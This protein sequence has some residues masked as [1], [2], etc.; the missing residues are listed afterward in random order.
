MLVFL[1][2]VIL[3][4]FFIEAFLQRRE[5]RRAR[6]ESATYY[7]WK[8]VTRDGVP[9]AQWRGQLE[10]ELAPGIVYRNRPNQAT[11]SFSINSRGFRGP[12]LPNSKFRP[13]ILLG[14]STA[15]GTGS[16]S[17]EHTIGFHLEKMLGIPIINA[18]VIG[19]R[20]G[21]ELNYLTSEL[22]TFQPQYVVSL[23]GWNDFSQLWLSDV[24][25]SSLGF[26]SFE[27]IDARLTEAEK[28]LGSSSV[29]RI[30]SLPLL[31]F[32]L[33][34]KKVQRLLRP[35]KS[36]NAL[37]DA[38][39]YIPIIAK[40]FA[41]NIELAAQLSQFR[42]AEYLCLLQPVRESG[43][44]NEMRL[45]GAYDL[46]RRQVRENLR[47]T[48]VRFYDLSDEKWS[49][50]LFVDLTHPTTQGP[51]SGQLRLAESIFHRLSEMRGT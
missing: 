37:D 23:G 22:L 49:V 50:D 19:H 41:R 5:S 40:T 30:L 13:L 24:E 47:S 38:E 16:P 9:F 25:K 10:L 20:S 33:V 8:Y 44:E 4:P 29:Q 18:A 32:P 39:K 43:D 17:D 2:L 35:K 15:F 46:F 45:L 11:S 3:T 1:I 26:C 42:N 51:R 28:L 48:R 12:E 27:L 34:T 36:R 6:L 31:F 21:Q 7:S 14:G